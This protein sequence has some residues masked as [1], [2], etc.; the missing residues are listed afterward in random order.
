M[1]ACVSTGYSLTQA[2]MCFGEKAGHHLGRGGEEGRPWSP[3]GWAVVW[4][5]VAVRFAPAVTTGPRALSRAL[6]QGDSGHEALL[7]T[8]MHPQGSHSRSH[9]WDGITRTQ[10]NAGDKEHKEHPQTAPPN[11]EPPRTSRAWG[12]PRE[13]ALWGAAL[14]GELCDPSS[15]LR[16][17]KA[18]GAGV[19]L[20]GGLE[21]RLGLP[22]GVPPLRKAARE[23]P[24]PPRLREH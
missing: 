10:P 12:Q 7:R 1:H 5:T 13:A 6:G 3:R 4:W 8:S 21:P 22:T 20:P 18:N 24:L 14:S 17:V 11:L 23:G 16:E 9:S 15:R 19:S 2:H